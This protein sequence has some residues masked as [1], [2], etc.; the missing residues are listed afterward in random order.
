MLLSRCL[1]ECLSKL[2]ACY[3][4]ASATEMPRICC[5]PT[6]LEEI[7]DAASIDL[8]DIGLRCILDGVLCVGSTD[9]IG[10]TNF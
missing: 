4:T 6:Y 10:C 3:L 7:F 2:L 5:P 1:G 9:F 8:C